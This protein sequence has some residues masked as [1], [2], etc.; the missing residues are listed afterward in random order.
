MLALAFIYL[1]ESLASKRVVEGAPPVVSFTG[2]HVNAALD[3]DVAAALD[4][5][6]VGV[7]RASCPLFAMIF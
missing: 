7:V 6:P 2:G 5:D 1:F 3:C 4:I